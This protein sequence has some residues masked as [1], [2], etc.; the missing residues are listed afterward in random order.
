MAKGQGRAGR[1]SASSSNGTAP[2]TPGRGPALLAASCSFP[3]PRTLM[4]ARRDT[5]AANRQIAIDYLRRHG[6][7]IA[8]YTDKAGEWTRPVSAIPLEERDTKRTE[9]SKALRELN[10]G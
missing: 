6:R 1:P 4:M 3:M 2:S 7:P 8:F 5:G 9:S 10:V